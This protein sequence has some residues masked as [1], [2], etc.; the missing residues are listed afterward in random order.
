MVL[1]VTIFLRLDRRI[2]IRRKIILRVL[3]LEIGAH[4]TH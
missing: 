1:E 4:I 2:D 3:T